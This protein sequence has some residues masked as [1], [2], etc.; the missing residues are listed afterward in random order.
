MDRDEIKNKVINIISALFSDAGVDTDMLEYVDLV[1]D[2]G[3]ESI[4][5]ISIVVEIEDRFDIIVPDDKLLIE[6]FR[7]V[8][9]IVTIISSEK[10]KTVSNV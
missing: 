1:D 4:T 9:D 7:K 10:R 5:F 2:L 6:N 8:D 3:M